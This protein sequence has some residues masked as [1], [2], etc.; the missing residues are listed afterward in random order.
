MRYANIIWQETNWHK[1]AAVNIG[2]NLQFLAI[3]YLYSQLGV[4]KDEIVYLHMSELKTYR[5]EKL[6]LPLNWS[7][8]DVNYM[9][10]EKLMIS[11]DIEPVFLGMSICS[12]DKD[13]FF[14]EHNIEYLKKHGPIGCRD[15]Y[16]Y[17]R[18]E[19]H[20]IAAY[21]NG[22]VSMLLPKRERLGEKLFMVD[23]PIEIKK[24][25]EEK[26]GS[27]YECCTQQM[28]LESEEEKENLRNIAIEHYKYILENA[29]LVVTSRLHILSPCL[30]LGIPVIFVRNMIDERFGWIDKLVR[31]YTCE[32]QKD[33]DWQPLA[34]ELEGIK[35]I[36][37]KNDIERIL[38]KNDEQENHKIH[39]Y[40]M[41]RE[42]GN[43][44]SFAQSLCKMESAK[45]YLHQKWKDDEKVHYVLWGANQNAKEL[46][47]Y[48]KDNFPNA[49]L[50]G[51]IDDY[52][53]G[54][55]LGMVCKMHEDIEI[56][57]ECYMVVTAVAASNVA[58]DYFNGRERMLLL[59]D[60][61]IS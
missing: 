14:C 49:R 27:E 43:Y 33:I 17:R 46:Y 44:V 41:E 38:G 18:L 12:R 2:D 23:A 40:F 32:E 51:V 36:I 52:K 31:L 20:G 57:E 48:I 21:V 39:E 28:Y 54:D 42:H 8:F 13:E 7:L 22:C 25:L 29:R 35:Q 47:E 56:E 11:S 45:K 24:A 61:F 50:A 10:D 1:S 53:K 9:E 55:F 30:A 15:E 37:L 5:G 26:L 4:S 34:V 16:T 59:G 3:D 58:Y 60:I 6:L 19:K